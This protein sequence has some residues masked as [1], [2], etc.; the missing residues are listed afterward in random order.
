LGEPI[1][2]HLAAFGLRDARRPEMGSNLSMFKKGLALIAIPL[3]FQLL[4]VGLMFQSQRAE[5]EAQRWANHTK[6]VIACAEGTSRSLTDAYSDVR[7]LG[8][9]GDPAFARNYRATSFQVG[10]RL[11]KLKSLVDDN[12]EQHARVAKIAAEVETFRGWL[13]ETVRLVLAGDKKAA[14]DR[15]TGMEGRR[16][17]DGIRNR[18]EE[19]LADEEHLASRREA[20][21]ERSWNRQSRLLITGVVV[22]L[23]LALGMTYLFSRGISGRLAILTGNVERLAVGGEL[24]APLEGGDEIGHLDR[25]FH[26]MARTLAARDRENEMFIYSVS[27]DLRSPLVNLQGFGKEL[28]LV[29]KDIRELLDKD[30]T[31]R[32]RERAKELLDR[33]VP[34]SIHFIQAAVSR[35]ASI[36]DALLRLS[37]A[38]RVE[39]RSQ[40]VDVDACVSK[41]V[42]ALGSTL[43]EKGVMV[44][45]S[46]LPQAWGD[47]AAIEQIFANL[48]GNS[49]N[50]LDS[51]RP[52]RIEIGSI[53]GDDHHAAELNTYYVKDNGQGIPEA[54]Q[55]KLFLAFQRFHKDSAPGEGIGLTLI[56]RAVERHGGTIRFESKVG[57]GS[58]FYVTLPSRE[59]DGNSTPQ[60]IGEMERGLY[61]S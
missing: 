57:E 28:E 3:L 43:T 40:W 17:L 32:A 24:A 25:V 52:G 14:N 6:D 60:R 21:L 33:D 45:T 42:E 4:F 48:V 26:D 12:P 23:G 53:N 59:P 9:S 27:H 22:S 35:L 29:C 51:K 44:T 56:R 54:Y 39:Y 38:G 13:G 7:S 34:E 15:I 16:L 61:G 19:V 58:T 5:A 18:F 2:G 37:R 50:Y 8:I 30:L 46:E 10:E 55:P 49:V 41:V 1:I 47:P 11:D 31:E 20:D 36:I